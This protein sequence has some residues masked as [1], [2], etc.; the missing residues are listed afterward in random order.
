MGGIP[1]PEEPWSDLGRL[2]TLPEVKN[3]SLFAP[4]FPTPD[5]PAHDANALTSATSAEPPRSESSA[6]EKQPQEL[7]A[8]TQTEPFCDAYGLI[9]NAMLALL[10]EPRG[11]DWLAETMCV[12]LAQ[13]R[14][15]LDRGVRE[16]KITKLK[17]P[18]RYVVHAQA[19][20]ELA[21]RSQSS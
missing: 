11:E 1:F 10:K 7:V 14:D 8:H 4:V 9:M 16:G 13:M 19:L 12:R 2:F 3:E 5:Q 21:N 20:L 17:K 6:G 18:V 15:W